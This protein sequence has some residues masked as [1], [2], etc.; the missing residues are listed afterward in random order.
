MNFMSLLW[1]LAFEKLPAFA[2]ILWDVLT[3]EFNI[4]GYDVSIWLMV[5]GVGAVVLGTI[6]FLKWVL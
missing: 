4:F 3:F 2:Q 6:L 1:E 5:G